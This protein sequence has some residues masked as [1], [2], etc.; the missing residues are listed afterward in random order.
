MSKN[1]KGLSILFA[2]V[3]TSVIAGMVM[4]LLFRNLSPVVKDPYK[5]KG[6]ELYENSGQVKSITYQ[7]K[8]DTCQRM[9]ERYTKDNQ[10]V[11]RKFFNNCLENE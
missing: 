6:I 5:I 9:V 8:K 7:S 1:R 2:G 3:A 11:E 4:V 10:F